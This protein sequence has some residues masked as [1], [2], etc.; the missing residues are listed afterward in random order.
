MM[1]DE[2]IQT[3]CPCCGSSCYYS[4]QSDGNGGITP[5]FSH[6]TRF[7]EDSEESA[8]IDEQG[9]DVPNCSGAGG[10]GN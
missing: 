5:M 2:I 3:I 4:E 8:L 6:E 1:I 7:L 9:S 10:G